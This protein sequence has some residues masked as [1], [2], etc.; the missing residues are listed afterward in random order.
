MNNLTTIALFTITSLFQSDFI[1]KWDQE[2]SKLDIIQGM[3]LYPEY[4][5]QYIKGDFFG[6][7]IDDYAL[8]VT[9]TTGRVKIVF[10]DKIDSRKI[11]ILG[12]ENDPFKSYNYRWA[13]IFEK[14]EKGK[15]LWSNYIDDFRTLSDVPDNERVYLNYNALYLHAAESCGGGFVYWKDGGFHWLQQE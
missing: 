13:E 11:Q 10:I 4:H 5:P 3:K 7:G 12:N 1:Q 6:D 9:D 2:Y 14:V 15:V 8:L